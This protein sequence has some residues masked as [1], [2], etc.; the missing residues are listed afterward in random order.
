MNSGENYAEMIAKLEEEKAELTM[1]LNQIVLHRTSQ[2]DYN[3][4]EDGAR[5]RQIE[6]N[7]HMAQGEIRMNEAI[8]SNTNEQRAVRERQEKAQNEL[9][10]MYQQKIREI[11]QNIIE[12]TRRMRGL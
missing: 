3:S 1:H 5:L 11:D 7:A 8:V 6:Y 10:Q 9:A 12:L 2:P 4:L